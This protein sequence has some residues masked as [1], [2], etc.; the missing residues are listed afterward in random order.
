MSDAL[1]SGASSVTIVTQTRVQAGKEEE[2]ARWQD[3]IAG[4]VAGFPGFIKQ[5]VMPPNPPTQVDWV[6]L[7]LFA[8]LDAAVVWLHSDQRTSL[9]RGHNPCWWGPTTFT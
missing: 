5:T 4:R 6:I 2:F 9:C 8:D 3:E 7:Q 1:P